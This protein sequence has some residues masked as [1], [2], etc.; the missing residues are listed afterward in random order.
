VECVLQVADWVDTTG[1]QQ[2]ELI[3]EDGKGT[4]V[5]PIHDVP[6]FARPKAIRSRFPTM[7]ATGRVPMIVNATVIGQRK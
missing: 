2:R 7:A 3:I 5:S 4:Q 6:T 1:S